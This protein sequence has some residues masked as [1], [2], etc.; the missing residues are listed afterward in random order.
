MSATGPRPRCP[1]RTARPP[2]RQISV[3]RAIADGEPGGVDDEV[4]LRG[5]RRAAVAGQDDLARAELTVASSSSSSRI[6]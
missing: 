4:E 1:S 5:R 3:A 6:P 2:G